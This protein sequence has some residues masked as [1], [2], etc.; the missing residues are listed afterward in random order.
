MLTRVNCRR[1]RRRLLPVA[2]WRGFCTVLLLGGPQLLKLS[3][4]SAT[5]LTPKGHLRRQNCSRP[6]AA[7]RKGADLQK[8]ADSADRVALRESQAKV[9]QLRKQISDLHEA[10]LQKTASV[11]ESRQVLPSRL[12]SRVPSSEAQALQKP[13]LLLQESELLGEK[14]AQATYRQNANVA[15]LSRMQQQAT[16]LRHRLTEA[17][18]SRQRM[19]KANARLQREVSC[20]ASVYGAALALFSGVTCFSALGSAAGGS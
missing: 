20:L 3:G 14:L 15:F 16:S 5:A 4:L 13:L 6:A 8:T 7:A 1:L 9:R 11:R 12:S 10:L 17:E 19:Q 18:A 2:C